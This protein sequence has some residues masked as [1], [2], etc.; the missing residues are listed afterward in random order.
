MIKRG[1]LVFDHQ[2]QGW[3]VWIGQQAY[4]FELRI[5]SRYFQA[6][7]EKEFDWFV[8][9]DGDVS[10]VLYYHEVYKV[11]I[12]TEEFIPVFAPF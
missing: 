9:L 2:E 3:K 10:F 1:I 6:Y 7:V 12:K 5:N 8:T 4:K 11:R